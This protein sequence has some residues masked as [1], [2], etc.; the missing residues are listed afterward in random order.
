MSINQHRF[1]SPV[2]W[3][4]GDRALQEPLFAF[5]GALLVGFGSQIWF[6][7]GVRRRGV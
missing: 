2:V 4:E 1:T 5:G 6:M 3:R 7:A